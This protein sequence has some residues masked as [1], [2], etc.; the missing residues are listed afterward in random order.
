[1][2]ATEPAA[3]KP[4][5]MPLPNYL[6]NKTFSLVAKAMNGMNVADLHSGMRG[7]RSSVIR[8]FY[9]DGEGDALP[10]DTLLWPARSGYRVVE[11]PIDYQDR[12]GQSKLRKV[13]GTVWTFIR[14][15]KTLARL[16]Q[17]ARKA[18]LPGERRPSAAD[19]EHRVALLDDD[20]DAEEGAGGI[21]AW[22]VRHGRRL[23]APSPARKRCGLGAAML[24]GLPCADA[25]P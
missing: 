5:A 23:S 16:D 24:C 22:G 21:V 19:E 14:L 7:Y 25:L 13:A 20:A 11:I 2:I 17:P 4:E 9:F 3:P 12:V 10:I 18:P 1:M 6:A 8:S 15:G